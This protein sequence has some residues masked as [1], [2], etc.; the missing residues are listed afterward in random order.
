M[1]GKILNFKA[2]HEVGGRQGEREEGG[3]AVFNELAAAATLMMM[4]LLT[5]LLLLL[6]EDAEMTMLWGMNS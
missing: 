3:V 5:M 4:L 1:H 6:L 2:D